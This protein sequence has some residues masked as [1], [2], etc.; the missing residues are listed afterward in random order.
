MCVCVYIYVY[1]HMR[2]LCSSVGI[3]NRYGMDG[4]GIESR[5]RRDFPHSSIMALNLTQPTMQLTE[6][7]FLRGKTAGVWLC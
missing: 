2:N 6:G 4:S 1:I 5:W 3:A 7:L